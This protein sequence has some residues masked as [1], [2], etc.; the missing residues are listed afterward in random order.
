MAVG[1]PARQNDG[2]GISEIL[3]LV[4]DE[5]DRFLQ[6]VSEGVKRVVVAIGPGKNDDSEFHEVAAPWNIWGTPILAHVGV[7]DSSVPS[8]QRLPGFSCEFDKTL[9]PLNLT[10]LSQACPFPCPPT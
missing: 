3:R 6:N 5:L 8:W 9:L 1:K 4:P 7:S 2:V 10:A